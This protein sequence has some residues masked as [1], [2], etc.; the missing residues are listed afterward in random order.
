MT[1][2]RL[3]FFTRCL[4]DTDIFVKIDTNCLNLF[5]LIIIYIITICVDILVNQ[6]KSSKY[7]YVI[8]RESVKK[9]EFLKVL[10]FIRLEHFV[11]LQ[12]SIVSDSKGKRK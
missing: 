10:E 12:L 3:S 1:D 7:V 9:L 2:F 11:S 6:S 5:I 8:G 4:K